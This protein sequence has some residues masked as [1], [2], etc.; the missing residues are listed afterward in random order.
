MYPLGIE[1]VIRWIRSIHR[2]IATQ[3]KLHIVTH[4]ATVKIKKM[5]RQSGKTEAE[6]K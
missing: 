6:D 2:L 5:S 1:I 4:K 3:S